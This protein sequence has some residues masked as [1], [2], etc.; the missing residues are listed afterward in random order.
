M[1]FYGNALM[2]YKKFAILG[3]SLLVAGLLVGATFG[4]ATANARSAEGQ[5]AQGDSSHPQSLAELKQA[6]EKGDADAQHALGLR[7]LK[8]QGVAK[9]YEKSAHWFSKAAAQG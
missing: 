2:C 7:Y 4:T 5:I 3:S 8:G 1:E 9:N 6:A